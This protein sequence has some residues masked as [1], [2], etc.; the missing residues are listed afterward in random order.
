MAVSRRPLDSSRLPEP[1]YQ[2]LV[3]VLS[4]V[5][6]GILAD[7]FWPLPIAA[8]GTLAAVGLV[9]WA[10]V[11]TSRWGP[12]ALVLVVIAACRRISPLSLWERGRVRAGGGRAATV[13]AALPVKPSPPGPSPKGRGEIFP[14][15]SSAMFCC[16][17]R[18]RRRR[19]RGGTAAGICSPPT[20]WAAMHATKPSRSVSRPWRLNRL[21]RCLPERPTRCE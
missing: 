2:P 1:R 13:A 10:I 7:R 3:I 21:G 4:A 9:L 14:T 16:S 12:L 19:G 15:S 6:A 17:W 5:A 20:T 18:W 8:W 11:T